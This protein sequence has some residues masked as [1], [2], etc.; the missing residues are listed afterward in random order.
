MEA[1]VL[2]ELNSADK[3]RGEGTTSNRGYKIFI[4]NEKA[5][6][7]VSYVNCK[8]LLS[9]LPVSHSV[10]QSFQFYWTLLHFLNSKQDT[11]SL[12]V[13]YIK[14]NYSTLHCRTSF[15]NQAVNVF[16]T[17]QHSFS[18]KTKTTDTVRYLLVID[19]E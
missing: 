8:L 4:A 12:T 13:L 2:K 9:L 15:L 10:L 11:I 6:T 5:L 18:M 17:D 1:A 16:Q 19:R 14:L 7:V 3:G